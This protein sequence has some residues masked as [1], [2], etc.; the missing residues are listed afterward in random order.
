MGIAHTSPVPDHCVNCGGNTPTKI[1]LNKGGQLVGVCG[2]CGVNK[3]SGAIE[4][5]MDQP[6]HVGRKRVRTSAPIVGAGS[7]VGGAADEDMRVLPTLTRAPEPPQDN[8]RRLPLPLPSIAESVVQP[9]QRVIATSAADVVE[10]ARLQLAELDAQIPAL[11]AELAAALA[12]RKGLAKMIAAYD[13][14][15]KPKPRRREASGEPLIADPGPPPESA[16]RP[17]DTITEAPIPEPVITEAAPA[18]GKPARQR[19]NGRFARTA[20]Q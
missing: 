14:V 10:G 2:V 1:D 5:V 7:K 18:P 19:V 3:G 8:V 16:P 11:E 12:H 17:T 15:P 6:A 13:G 20:A 9:R 4:M